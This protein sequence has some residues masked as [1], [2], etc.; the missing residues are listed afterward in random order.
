MILRHLVV[1][2]VFAIG[3][4]AQGNLGGFTGT[5]MDT[6]KASFRRPS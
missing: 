4:F 2:G 3:A 5:V 6:S 1:A